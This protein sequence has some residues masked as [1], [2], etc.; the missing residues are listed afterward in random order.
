M[1]ALHLAARC[2]P[3]RYRDL[4]ESSYRWAPERSSAD[5]IRVKLLGFAASQSGQVELGFDFHPT[6]L[7][8]G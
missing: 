6:D 4:A 8:P 7:V 1:A 2:S 5:T 3:V